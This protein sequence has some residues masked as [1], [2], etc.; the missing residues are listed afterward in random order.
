[1]KYVDAENLDNLSGIK[2]DDN[3]TFLFQCHPDV[4]CFN[5]CCRNLNLFLYP[6]DVIRLKKR[7]GIT[8]DQFLNEYVDVV[9]RASSFFPEVLL[10]MS[11]NQE[12][13]CIFSTPEGCS[14][15]SDRPNTCRF[16]PVEQGALFDAGTGKTKMIHF[17]R[18]P[19]F[20]RGPRESKTWTA[21]TWARGQGAD[22]Y[23]KMT[24]LW[25]ELKRL[26]RNDPWGGQG[27][28]CSKGKMAFMAAYNTDMF[29]DFVFKS[30]FLKRYRVKPSVLKK[31]KKD[32]AEMLK[33]GF[34]WIKFFL[35]GIKPG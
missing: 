4:S 17:F 7:L 10:Q 28:E 31:A 5:M 11:D 6:Y 23:H 1:M 32:D 15:Y 13:T 21:K 18:P 19:D 25:S 26:F 22:D 35:W 20:C 12:K 27:I 29:R 14:V 33:L 9:M 2:L 3:D 30:S 24:L 34:E 8:S 16:F